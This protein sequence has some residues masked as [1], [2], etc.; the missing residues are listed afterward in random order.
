MINTWQPLDSKS[1]TLDLT[2]LQHFAELGLQVLQQPYELNTV[3]NAEQQKQAQSWLNLPESAW[4][5][6]IKQ[7]PVTALL[8]LAA[9]FTLAEMQLNGWQ[10]GDQNPAIWLFRWLRQQQ[11]PNKEDILK[12]KQLTT[13]RFIP[14]GNVLG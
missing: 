12:L 6:S 4:Q 7:L 2:L 3:V 14:Y 5:D 9:F 1:A 13:N 8:P 10:C 11:Q